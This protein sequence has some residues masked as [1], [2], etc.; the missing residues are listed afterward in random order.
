VSAEPTIVQR[1]VSWPRIQAEA[2]RW[3]RQMLDI[4]GG[5]GQVAVVLHWYNGRFQGYHCEVRG[6]RKEPSP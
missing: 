1:S 5:C 4:Q 3:M 6:S 2:E